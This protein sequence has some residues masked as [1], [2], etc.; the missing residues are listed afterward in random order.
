MHLQDEEFDRKLKKKK[1]KKKDK[2]K[3]D[4][5][6]KKSKSKSKKVLNRSEWDLFTPM[7]RAEEIEAVKKSKK[8][9]KNKQKKKKKKPETA[10][11]AD[12]KFYSS[13]VSEI[14][15]N[16]SPSVRKIVKKSVGDQSKVTSKQPTKFNRY[17]TGEWKNLY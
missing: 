12:G 13:D 3:K 16:L 2:D 5:K 17:Y 15:G 1:S 11:P 7:K 10:K 9:L 14:I 4:K 8:D 6:H